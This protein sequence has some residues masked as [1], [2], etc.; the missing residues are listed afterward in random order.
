MALIS[1]FLKPHRPP[2]ELHPTGVSTQ[3]GHISKLNIYAH[4]KPNAKS[5]HVPDLIIFIV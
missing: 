3:M 4:L 2:A 5:L 1:V